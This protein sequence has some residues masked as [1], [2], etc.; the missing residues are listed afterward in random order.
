VGLML[1]MDLQLRAR[2][3]DGCRETP[4]PSWVTSLFALLALLTILAISPMRDGCS[5]FTEKALDG[6]RYSLSGG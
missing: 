4:T 1:G 5:H 6:A 3:R 2:S